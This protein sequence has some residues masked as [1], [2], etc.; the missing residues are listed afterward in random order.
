M[1]IFYNS[2][3]DFFRGFLNK[4]VV[5]F[6]CLTICSIDEKLGVVFMNIK[7]LLLTFAACTFLVQSPSFAGGGEGDSDFAQQRARAAKRYHER[8]EN[9]TQ[10][11]LDVQLKRVQQFVE[12][13]QDQG[14]SVKLVLGSTNI[15]NERISDPSY[16][17]MDLDFH[18]PEGA[19]HI[20]GDFNDLDLL[21]KIAT[22]TGPSLDQIVLDGAVY[23]FNEWTRAHLGAFASMLK[24]SGEFLFDPYV[25]SRGYSEFVSLS[26]PSEAK[27]AMISL[28]DKTSFPDVSLPHSLIEPMILFSDPELD[29][30]TLQEIDAKILKAKRVLS[31]SE[32]ASLFAWVEKWSAL[33][34]QQKREITEKMTPEEKEE[35]DREGSEQKQK[36]KEFEKLCGINPW[37][38]VK[39]SEE[40]LKQEIISDKKRAIKNDESAKASSIIRGRFWNETMIHHILRSVGEAFDDV[41]LQRGED[42]PFADNRGVTSVPYLVT[43]KKPKRGQ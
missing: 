7:S 43:A 29:V 9:V 19:P 14:D 21:R 17:F 26:S 8:A 22:V 25:R 16:I 15:D 24:N 36:I 4:R 32:Y 39:I 5:L 11:S 3:E 10:L 38:L 30:A 23:H 40:E 27:E 33:S 28:L 12:S 41:T 31:T 18:D 13:R 35:F 34:R 42:R 6:A 20:R 2:G 1:D 37:H